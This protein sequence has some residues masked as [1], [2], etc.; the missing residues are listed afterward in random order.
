V[1]DLA[2]FFKA[3]SCV[4]FNDDGLLISGRHFFDCLVNKFHLDCSQDH[5]LDIFEHLSSR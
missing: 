1:I 3:Q 2:R 5:L 4:S